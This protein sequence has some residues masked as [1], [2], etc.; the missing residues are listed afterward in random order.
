MTLRAQL[1]AIRVGGLAQ[2]A[3][4]GAILA[5]LTTEDSA[6]IMSSVPVSNPSDA[7]CVHP[8]DQRIDAGRMGAPH[9]WVCGVCG[10]SGD[11]FVEG[12]TS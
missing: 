12:G 9:A 5:V 4:A 1:E 7:R 2:A 11:L 10:Q 6:P 3:M 8:V